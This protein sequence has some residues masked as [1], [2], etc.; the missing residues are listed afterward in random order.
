MAFL[1]ALSWFFMAWGCWWSNTIKHLNQWEGNSVGSRPIRVA[2]TEPGPVRGDVWPGVFQ[3]LTIEEILPARTVSPAGRSVM[4]AYSV[5][6]HTST[7]T[8]P[9]SLSSSRSTENV[10]QNILQG[11]NLFQGLL[12]NLRWNGDLAGFDQ[13]KFNP[14]PQVSSSSSSSS[15]SHHNLHHDNSDGG[16]TTGLW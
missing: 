15:F 11:L 16:N 6:T 9:P 12:P 5:V 4:T 1:G 3:E 8:N 14:P 2:K 13:T 10:N 7:I